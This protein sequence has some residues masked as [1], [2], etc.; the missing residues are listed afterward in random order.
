M[1]G[2]LITGTAG[3][4][5]TT[6][7]KN[8]VNWLRREF[9]AEVRAVNLDPGVHD[10]PYQAIFDARDIVKIDELMVLGELG[11]NGALIRANEVL[12]ERVDE[13]IERVAEPDFDYIGHRYSRS[14]GGICIEMGWKDHC[15]RVKEGHELSRG[16]SR[17]S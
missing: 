2:I 15:R 14:N 9:N 1:Q 11:P 10:L 5:K 7:T 4:G 6:L 8:L 3:S 12:A 13:L 16:L 17:G